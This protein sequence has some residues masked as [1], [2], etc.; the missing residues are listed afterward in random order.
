[1]NLSHKEINQY[2]TEQ[3]HLSICYVTHTC[4]TFKMFSPEHALLP[5]ECHGS[6]QQVAEEEHHVS[7]TQAWQQVVESVVHGPAQVKYLVL[8]QNN[9]KLKLTFW[10][11]PV[12]KLNLPAFLTRLKLLSEFLLSKTSKTTK[13]YHC[14]TVT[15]NILKFFLSWYSHSVFQT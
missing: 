14:T 4:S 13:N 3:P 7:C 9:E 8:D 12:D 6:D 1:M 5:A 10:T 15:F 2:C 11:R